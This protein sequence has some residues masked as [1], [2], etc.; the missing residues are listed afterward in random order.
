MEVNKIKQYFL[1]KNL[2]EVDED[3]IRSLEIKPTLAFTDGENRIFVNILPLKAIGN[4]SQFIKFMMET[5]ALKEKCNMM[6]IVIPSL[7]ATIID[8]EILK[9]MGIGLIILTGEK[10][11]EVLPAKKHKPKIIIEANL[12]EQIKHIS[13]RI[14][15]IEV[16][17]QRL[18]GQ[19]NQIIR[20][21]SRTEPIK[22]ITIEKP[23]E[24]RIEVS[25]LP[26]Y[27]QNNPWLQILRGRGE[28]EIAK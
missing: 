28:R 18:E 12:T 9:E 8:S 20:K 6:Y 25:G 7:M 1:S 13:N 19:I 14:E 22:P 4:R 11:R 17:I 2:I 15:R 10:L 27:M 21:M 24:T 3:E 16:Y 26:S 5:S 23:V